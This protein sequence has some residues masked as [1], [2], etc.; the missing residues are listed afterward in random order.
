MESDDGTVYAIAFAMLCFASAIAL[1]VKRLSQPAH[2]DF[3]HT[4]K[5]FTADWTWREKTFHHELRSHLEEALANAPLEKVITEAG[6]TGTTVRV[7]L[8]ALYGDVDWL[9][10]VKKG[11]T[12]QKVMTLVGEVNDILHHWRSSKDRKAR[13]VVV[14]Y[15]LERAGGDNQM[16]KLVDLLMKAGASRPDIDVQ[17]VITNPREL[18]TSTTAAIPRS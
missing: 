17:C 13:L 12:S 8:H 11:L 5:G 16:A 7:D 3:L 14:L 6:L 10:T 2:P 18:A 15:G 1:L 4:L 9:I